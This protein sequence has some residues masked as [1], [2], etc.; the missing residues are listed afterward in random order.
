MINGILEYYWL[1]SFKLKPP[2]HDAILILDKNLHLSQIKL[3]LY[4]KYKLSSSN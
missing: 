3:G 1:M 2:I 4:S